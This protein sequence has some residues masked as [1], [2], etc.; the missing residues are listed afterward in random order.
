MQKYNFLGLVLANFQGD[1]PGS[2]VS[3]LLSEMALCL[4]LPQALTT[5]V[6]P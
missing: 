4:I 1:G 2:L 3:Q 5:L 6:T